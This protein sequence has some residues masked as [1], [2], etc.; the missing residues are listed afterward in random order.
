MT[1]ADSRPNTMKPKWKSEPGEWLVKWMDIVGE[2]SARKPE[3]RHLSRYIYI[4]D[5]TAE[6]HLY[7]WILDNQIFRL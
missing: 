2:L 6:Y 7:N 1:V 4:G 3:S 5:Y